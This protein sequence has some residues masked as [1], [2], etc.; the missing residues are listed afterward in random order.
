[1]GVYLIDC[2]MIVSLK[3]CLHTK[4][5]LEVSHL[6]QTGGKGKIQ[7]WI[8]WKQLSVLSFYTTDKRT[9]G[10]LYCLSATEGFRK[11][12]S[13]SSAS[14]CIKTNLLQC[15]ITSLWARRQQRGNWV[16]T[17]ASQMSI[18]QRRFFQGFHAVP[19]RVTFPLTA[20]NLGVYVCKCMG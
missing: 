8:I 10:F 5:H 7:Y 4:G 6:W 2:F 13:I 1:M 11:K 14:K 12:C 20:S 19:V 3:S 9:A 18:Y 16:V 15:L 17:T